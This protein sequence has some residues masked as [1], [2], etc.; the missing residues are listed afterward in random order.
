MIDDNMRIFVK[1]HVQ[2]V[3]SHTAKIQDE[4]SFNK[5]TFKTSN[6]AEIILL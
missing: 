4:I 6:G 3:L 2:A 5:I 1:L